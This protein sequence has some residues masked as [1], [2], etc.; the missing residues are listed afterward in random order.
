MSHPLQATTLQRRRQV[1]GK[2]LATVHYT[3]HR[4]EVHLRINNPTRIYLVPF[5]RN[6]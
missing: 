2:H 5:Y 1:W 4:I 3:L 6:K